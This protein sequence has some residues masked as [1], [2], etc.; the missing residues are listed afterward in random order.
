[1]LFF[2]A[3]ND[4]SNMTAAQIDAMK[5]RISDVFSAA[6]QQISFLPANARGA[7]YNLTLVATAPSNVRSSVVGST[8]LARGIGSA[9]T[10]NGRVYVDRLSNSA[11]ATT[12]GKI[13]FPA[14]PN[15][16]GYGVGTAA[17]H[18]IGHYLLQQNFDNPAIAGIMHAS[19]IGADWFGA[20]RTFTAAQVAILN[21]R[22][23]PASTSTDLPNTT[24]PPRP[25]RPTIDSEGGRIGI[26]AR[27]YPGWYMS[28][29]SLLDWVH[30]IGSGGYGEVVGYE[31]KPPKK[32]P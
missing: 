17:S 15:F 23:A 16:V 30:S 5:R 2:V 32:T 10:N 14:F 31:I 18:E 22:Y 12:A 6:G 24:L 26:Y 25:I 20:L 13:L 3:L 19:F 4:Q 8:D 11:M 29:W 1:M 21:R 28:M 7:D 9:V 27:G